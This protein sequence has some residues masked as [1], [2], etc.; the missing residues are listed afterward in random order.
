MSDKEQGRPKARLPKGL[1]DR[2]AAEIRARDTIVARIRD[3]YELHGFE[4][5]ET[6]TIEYADAL[7]KFLPDQDRPN[8]GVFSF[9]DD[10]EQWLSLRYDHTAPLARYVAQ[11]FDELPKPYRRYQFGMLWRNEKPGP[12][13][14]REFL[15][16]DADTVG[17]ANMAADAE[18]VALLA[19]TMEAVGFKRGEYRVRVNNRKVLTG[20]LEVAG[21][22]NAGAEFSQ[23]VLTVLR[24]IDKLDRLG[25]DGVAM[26]LGKG[27]RDESGDFTPGAELGAEQD[28]AHPRFRRGRPGASR[29]QVCRRFKVSS[30]T[31]RK[32][33]PAW[34]SSS[35]SPS[36]WRLGGTRRKR[37]V[38]DPS[39]VRGLGYYTGPVFE[40]ELT[41]DVFDEKGVKI[42]FG[43]VGA[44]GRYDD[45]IK[46][47]KGIEV[48]AT[49]ASMGVSRLMAALVARDRGR[50]QAVRRPGGRACDGRR[51]DRVPISRWSSELRNAGSGASFIS[52]ARACARSS[53]MPTS[54][55]AR[56][57]SSKGEDERAKG[58]VTLKDLILGAQMAAQRRRQQDVARGSARAGQHQ[59]RRA[60]R[61]RCARC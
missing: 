17:S 47:F 10:D 59:A 30:A 32:A 1:F 57:P 44:G 3:I 14:F 9:Q 42:P 43:S 55:A 52:A 15:Q 13:R 27:R 40:A 33:T 4:P 23:R 11:R 18:M 34:P 7:G 22:I 48:P 5:L 8:E 31:T 12:G 2:E 25:R 50:A 60:G 39:V 21:V 54:A 6:P 37:A 51:A 29:A 56:S 58:E 38:F 35:G 28:R 61:R 49:G 53:N 24:A 20:V 26:L 16:F 36:S 41:F 19:D 45:L 46:R